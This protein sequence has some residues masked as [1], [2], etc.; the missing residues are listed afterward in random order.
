[1][2]YENLREALN[3]EWF[4]K[5][6][7]QIRFKERNGGVQS[8]RLRVQEASICSMLGALDGVAGASDQWVLEWLEALN[9]EGKRLAHSA[10]GNRRASLEDECRSIH[11]AMASIG[12]SI[13]SGPPRREL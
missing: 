9:V 12:R 5:T 10:L 3:R 6:Q 7:E 1:M 13:P 8:R 11:I 4:E 2:L